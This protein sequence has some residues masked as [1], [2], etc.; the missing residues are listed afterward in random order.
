MEI[1]Y[2]SKYFII[3]KKKWA[4]SLS[5][6]NVAHGYKWISFRLN[7]WHS[8]KSYHNNNINKNNSSITTK[9]KMKKK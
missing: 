3:F 9:H 4:S 2:L 5:A 6:Y 1:F 8:I 7:C